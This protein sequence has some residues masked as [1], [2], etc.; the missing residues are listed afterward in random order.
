[1]LTK[2]NLIGFGV[3]GL[4]AAALYVVKADNKLLKN[5]LAAEKSAK[6]KV[7]EDFRLFKESKDKMDTVIDNHT[8]Q[9][10]E[11]RHV[12]KVVVKTVT[13]YK[14]R[15]VND[16]SVDDDWVRIHD[17]AATRVSENTDTE[18]T[19]GTDAKPEGDKVK[20]SDALEVVTDNYLLYHQCQ[21]RLS[22]LQEAVRVY[23]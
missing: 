21:L 2:I 22:S 15:V 23:Q 17:Y 1:M 10:E 19:N 18:G 8:E 4:L 20:L 5:D 7:T 16:C 12:E 9:K 3:I 14:T 11:I 6:E 13:E